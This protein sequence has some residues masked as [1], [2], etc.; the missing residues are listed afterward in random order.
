MSLIAIRQIHAASAP[1]LLNQEWFVVENTSERPFSTAGC[2][3]AIGKSKASR[4]KPMGTLDPGFTLA[5]E[6]KVRVVTG[7]PG[8]KAQGQPP[9]DDGV[10]TYHLFLSSPLLSG[11]GSILAVALGQHELCRA[12]FDPKAADGVAPSKNGA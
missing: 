9:A 7:N 3:I 12:A 1:A 4:L 8:K 10:R 5:P 11:A 2:T 6:E